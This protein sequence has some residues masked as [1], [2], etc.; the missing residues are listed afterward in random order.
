[1]TVQ[2]VQNFT[3]NNSKANVSNYGASNV[4]S[5]MGNSNQV[6]DAFTKSSQVTFKGNLA[7]VGEN[8]LGDAG[9]KIGGKVKR[10]GEEAT[11][12]IGGAV[13]KIKGKDDLSISD[14]PI[15][16]NIQTND[17]MKAELEQN[18][19]DWTD[20]SGHKQASE[21]AIKAS[22]H[23]VSSG[24]IDQNGYLTTS[25]KDKV[26]DP[27][28]GNNNDGSGADSGD[29]SG[30]DGGDVDGVDTSGYG[31]GEVNDCNFDCDSGDDIDPTSFM[32]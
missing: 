28:F 30:Y 14:K 11:E 1:M 17:K 13:R 2:A 21:D 24:D 20:I 12:I 25:G 9:S 16:C 8:L 4:M 3:T 23:D 31:G 32:S 7:K 29:L 5:K 19:K 22:G 18:A 27:A 6:A 15:T 26:N 10:L